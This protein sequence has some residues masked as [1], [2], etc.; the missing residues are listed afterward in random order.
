MYFWKTQ[1]LAKQIKDD[2]ITEESK[3][4]Y[5]LATSLITIAGMYLTL[6]GGM[7]NSMATLTECILLLIITALAI[8]IV[9]AT[10]RGNDGI[11]FI[12]RVVILGFPIL[13]KIMVLAF[14]IGIAMGIYS[15]ASG[16]L[17]NSINGWDNAIIAVTVQIFFFWRI[18]VHMSYIN[19]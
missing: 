7:Q 16:Q 5:Y 6:A 15:G 1:E 13:I 17:E 4:N 18:N 3:K 9:F 10:N 11:D 19:T 2:T 12:S 8:N 14:L